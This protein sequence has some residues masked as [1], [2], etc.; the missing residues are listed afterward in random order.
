MLAVDGVVCDVVGAEPV[1]RV[2]CLQDGNVPSIFSILD[3]HLLVQNS[4]W[5]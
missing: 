5:R 2:E 1:E 3:K 4:A